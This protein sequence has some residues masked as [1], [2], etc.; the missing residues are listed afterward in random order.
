MGRGDRNLP[1][2]WLVRVAGQ[3]G[4]SMKSENLLVLPAPPEFSNVALSPGSRVEVCGLK[5]PELNGQQGQVVHWDEQIERWKVRMDDGTG[6]MFKRDNLAKVAVSS[7]P[8][9]KSAEEEGFGRQ[10]PWSVS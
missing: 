9:F 2:W 4:V 1:G 7:P 8:N 5:L 6:K 10:Q 3:K